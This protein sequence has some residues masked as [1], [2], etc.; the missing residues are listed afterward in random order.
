MIQQRGGERCL[1][2]N[3]PCEKCTET[4]YEIIYN[5]EKKFIV[6]CLRCGKVYDFIEI[7]SE[8]EE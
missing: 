8:V 5:S 3:Y 2:E 1:A 4:G 7:I 6:S